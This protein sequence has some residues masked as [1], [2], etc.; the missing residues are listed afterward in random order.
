MAKKAQ[1]LEQLRK[2]YSSGAA[3]EMV[4]DGE[5]AL[6]L[7]SGVIA[8][9]HRLG[10][11]I[12]YGRILEIFGEES[13]GKSL[14]AYHFAESTHDLGGQVLWVDAEQ[15]YT[16][17]WASSLGLDNQRVE[18]FDEVAVELISDWIADMVPYYRSQL[19]NNEPILL[20]VDS[21]AAL[22]TQSSLESDQSDSKAEM[23]NRAKA[24]YKMLRLR[25]KMFVQLGVCVIFINQLRKKLD[26]GMFGDPDTTPGGAAMKFFASLRL[27]ITGGKQ[28]KN[29]KNKRIGRE[30]HMRVI[31][32]KVA[33][34]SDGIKGI[35]VY[36]NEK[37]SDI[38]GFERLYDL[39][40]I[41]LDTGVVTRKKGASRYFLKEEVLANGEDN[42][43][44]LLAKDE[45]LREKLIRKAGINTLAR[46][47]RQLKKLTE[48]LYPVEE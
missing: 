35:P 29:S 23:G 19:T 2:K 17:D 26:A 20:V 44:K 33:P 8:V 32:N 41:L 16:Q 18:L 5:E 15:A 30:S 1:S 9:D 43:L 11:G 31:K 7:P 39:P 46:T 25:N 6:W 22:D 40:N 36:F 34:P 13:S 3:S 45:K 42:F 24:I 38:L 28:I 37:H 47:Q 21:T 48:N 12:P 14:L 27:G 10:G 4:L